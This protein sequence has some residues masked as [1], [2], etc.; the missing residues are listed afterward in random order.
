[1]LLNCLNCY[2]VYELEYQQSNSSVW[3]AS[4]TWH[5]PNGQTG[6][7]ATKKTVTVPYTQTVSASLP[8]STDRNLYLHYLTWLCT[9][10]SLSP[11]MGIYPQDPSATGA[12]KVRTARAELKKNR[13][14]DNC[15]RGKRVTKL[16][17]CPNLQGAVWIQTTYMMRRAKLASSCSVWGSLWQLG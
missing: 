10:T 13:S 2:F 15:G 4:W 1:M 8:F 11:G 9:S 16:R 5:L 7:C 14:M 3:A 17:K 6:S 12:K